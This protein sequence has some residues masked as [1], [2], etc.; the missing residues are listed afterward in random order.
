MKKLSMLLALAV[1]LTGLALPAL[2]AEGDTVLM[3]DNN[4]VGGI[5]SVGDTFYILAASYE[6]T[7]QGTAI[8]HQLYSWHVGDSEP[9]LFAEGVLPEARSEDDYLSTWSFLSGDESGFYAVSPDAGVIQKLS[10][11]DGV[12]AADGDPVYFDTEDLVDSS[13]Y[14]DQEYRY[15]K[16]TEAW[17]LM[18]GKFYFVLQDYEMG[19]EQQYQLIAIDA[20]TGDMTRF[21]TPYI[22]QITP[23]QDGK[24]LVLA[25]DERNAYDSEKDE[26]NPVTISV[27]D[28]ETDSLADYTTVAGTK[29][30]DISAMHYFRELDAVYF[31][32]SEKI[33]RCQ[34]GG[35]AEIAAYVPVSYIWSHG[36]GSVV[37]WVGDTAMVKSDTNGLVGLFVRRADPALV[38]TQTLTISGGYA[39][40]AHN[41][42]LAA[43]GDIPVTFSDTYFSSAQELGELLVSGDCDIDIFSVSL[44]W[45][46]FNRLMEK[47]Y[48]YDLTDTPAVKDFYDSLYP[49][50]QDVV[51]LDG[52]VYGVP[53]SLQ[54]DGYV[55]ANTEALEETGLSAPASFVGLCDFINTWGEG[56]YY[57]TF[58][59]CL[60]IEDLDSDYRQM[61][62]RNAMDLYK[63]YMLKTGQ[64]LT[65]DT[66]LF[67]ELF[68]AVE[69][70]DAS[71]YAEDLDWGDEDA[72]NEYFNKRNLLSTNY[73]GDITPRGRDESNIQLYFLSPTDDTEPVAGVRV[74]VFFVNPRS[75]N[76]D[77]AIQYI[78]A[79]IDAMDEEDK[80]AMCPG[81]NEPV[82]NPYY[83]QNL[84]SMEQTIASLQDSVDAA[85]AADKPALEEELASYRE[86]YEDY[87]ENDRYSITDE[88]IARYREW[89]NSFVIETYDPFS[90]S[91]NAFQRYLDGQINLEQYIQE[92]ESTLWKIRNE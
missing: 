86:Y 77:A 78:T 8:T 68:Q 44:S 63:N 38:P 7:G 36:G 4:S 28:P 11:A 80:I 89:V 24:L 34:A 31:I 66:P 27:F 20:A 81:R 25:V 32:G 70:T 2:A 92:A 57:D 17:E 14:N 42:T 30:F 67:R 62:A 71:D 45:M 52:H 56:E 41:R 50:L 59:D 75:K 12:L 72:M 54:V 37:A 91:D 9:A 19:P 83:E 88:S 84:E 39:S 73:I 82:L 55:R 49:M 21:D 26:Y 10:A 90:G 43:M 40:E 64:E 1:I 74:E 23:Y 18:D 3:K 76:I 29:Y 51:A 33:Y 47:G 60:P 6:G 58:S 15:F 5:F 22:H 35:E 69:N 65:F 53:T 46:D 16:S 48:C 87:K 85:E 13:E 79:Y 61:L